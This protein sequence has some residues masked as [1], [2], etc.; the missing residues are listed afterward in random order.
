MTNLNWWKENWKVNLPD[1]QKILKSKISNFIDEE[2]IIRLDNWVT[3]R[4]TNIKMKWW[5]YQF[6]WKEYYVC[7]DKKDLINHIKWNKKLNIDNTR[8][9]LNQLITTFV[10]DMSQLFL[11]M[12][13]FNEDISNWDTENVI[14]MREMFWYCLNFNCDIFNWNTSNVK[15]MWWMFTQAETF[16][17]DISNWNTSNVENLEWMFYYAKRFNQPIWK[18]NT[19]NVKNMRTMFQWTEYFNQD[20][21]KWNVENVTSHNLFDEKTNMRW[22]QESKPKFKN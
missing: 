21:S 11:G 16:N 19:S 2:K 18:W 7:R 4:A 12:K 15:N 14:N 5:I 13:E 8:F 17:C 20:L 9:K 22:K 6:E 1:I 3:L 10:T